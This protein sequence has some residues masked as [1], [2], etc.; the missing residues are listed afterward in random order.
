MGVCEDA[1][2]AYRYDYKQST[3]INVKAVLYVGFRMLTVS[4]LKCNGIC[5]YPLADLLSNLFGNSTDF[6]P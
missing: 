2:Y 4:F 3:E 6:S 5:F 1:P